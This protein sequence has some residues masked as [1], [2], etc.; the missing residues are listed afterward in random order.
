MEKKQEQ[1]TTE[2][3]K[4]IPNRIFRGRIVEFVRQNVGKEMS[5]FGFGKAVKKDYAQSEQEWLLGLCQKLEKEK[6][7]K[8]V[9]INKNIKINLSV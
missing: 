2:N 7:I 3:G 4:F 9:I 1:G 5:I 8:V 6:I